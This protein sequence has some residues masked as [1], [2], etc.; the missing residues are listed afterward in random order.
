MVSVGITKDGM[1]NRKVDPCVV[2]GLGVKLTPFCV[3][4]GTTVDVSE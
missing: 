2:C 1:S 4:S 3:V